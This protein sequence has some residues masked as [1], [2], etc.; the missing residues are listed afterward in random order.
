MP[1]DASIIDSLAY[2]PIGL[3]K[4]VLDENG[5]YVAGNHTIDTFASSDPFLLPP[6][7]HAVHGTFGAII[8]V[9][10]AIPVVE[11]WADGYD[12]GGAI[13]V[14]GR[15]YYDRFAQIVLLHQIIT[16]FYVAIQRFELHYLSDV[17]FWPLRLVGGDRFG[18]HVEPAIAVDV[19]FLCLP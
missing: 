13:G 18:L 17:M 16:G 2:P 4:A 11:G 3:L 9:N 19:Y 10:G 12:S 1:V 14:E 6:G 15:F 7:P 8:Q 5:P